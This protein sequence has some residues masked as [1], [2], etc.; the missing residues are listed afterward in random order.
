VR[1]FGKVAALLAAV[2]LMA[3]APDNAPLPA[4]PQA[5]RSAQ[6]PLPPGH[7]ASVQKAQLFGAGLGVT[8]AAAAIAGIVVVLS[9]GGSKGAAS[10]QSI[11]V[12]T[13]ATATTE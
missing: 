6:T 12:T 3:Q 7:A 4:A 1:D 8:A 11:L 5:G 2:S 10:P 9:G 13:T